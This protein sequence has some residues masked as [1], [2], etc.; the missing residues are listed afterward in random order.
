MLSIENL[1]YRAKETQKVKTKKNRKSTRVKPP[2][3]KNAAYVLALFAE[4]IWR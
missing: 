2:S 3:T 1:N 4:N